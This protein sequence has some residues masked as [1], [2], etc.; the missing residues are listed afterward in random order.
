MLE[1]VINSSPGGVS[2]KDFHWSGGMYSPKFERTNEKLLEAE[3]YEYGLE[4]SKEIVR[5]PYFPPIFEKPIF[6]E[7]NHEKRLKKRVDAKVE[8]WEFPKPTFHLIS[9]QLLFSFLF[10]SIFFEKIFGHFILF[11]IPTWLNLTLMM[12]FFFI[13]LN[14]LNIF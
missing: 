13:S 10:F 11:S 14:L 12:T 7:K 5:T 1:R 4:N 6:V 8:P 9:P 3:P 2:L